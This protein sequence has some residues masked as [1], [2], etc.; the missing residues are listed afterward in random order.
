MRRLW[1]FLVVAALLTTACNSASGSDWKS[2]A[3]ISYVMPT[4]LPSGWTLAY[5]TERP[6]RPV[7]D[8][9]SHAE[10][11]EHEARDEFVI[12]HASREPRGK[13]T[14]PGTPIAGENNDFLL[15]PL[16]L[17]VAGDVED[18]EKLKSLGT[19][20]MSSSLGLAV[21]HIA[22][23]P[24]QSLLMQ[25]AAKFEREADLDF[26]APDS[27]A[28]GFTR[29]G[30]GGQEVTDYTIVFAPK[31]YA[32]ST[33]KQATTLADDAPSMSINVGARFYAQRP[34]IPELAEAKIERED[35][36]R[37]SLDFT[38]HGSSMGISSD[39]L[40]RQQ[41]LAV[42]RSLKNYSRAEWRTLLG[43]R[44][45]TQDPPDER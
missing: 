45:F 5:A 22:R 16:M 41:L 13:P 21:T 26:A 6:G 39:S 20:W 25:V 33:R 24:S 28:P 36:G 18:Y 23:R 7:E 11:Y 19:S 40:S 9:E 38:Q 2:L 32:G 8:W 42:A 15:S 29:A 14:K 12:V 17:Y 31:Q 27:V 4:H 43:S 44:L 34:E 35:K 1:A 37:L 30:G 3:D 10:L